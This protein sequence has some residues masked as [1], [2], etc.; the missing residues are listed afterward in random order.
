MFKIITTTS[1]ATAIDNTLAAATTLNITTSISATPSIPVAAAVSR[2]DHLRRCCSE[3]LHFVCKCT[4][5]IVSVLCVHI[6]LHPCAPTC[7]Y[8]YTHT[9]SVPGMSIFIQVCVRECEC[10]LVHNVHAFTL[11]R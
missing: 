10:M 4:F 3:Y 11:R 6:S 1:L 2:A 8:T 7:V 9:Y 5:H